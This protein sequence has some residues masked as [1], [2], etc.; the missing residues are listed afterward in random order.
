MSTVSTGSSVASST[1]QQQQQQQQQ[2]QQ[3]QYPPSASPPLPSPRTARILGGHH[4]SSA[5]TSPVSSSATPIP[6]LV[7]G[8][9]NAA[10]SLVGQLLSASG[11]TATGGATPYGMIVSAGASS[12]APEPLSSLP[13]GATTPGVGMGGIQATGEERPELRRRETSCSNVAVAGKAVELEPLELQIPEVAGYTD[14]SPVYSINHIHV[15]RAR[16]S[17]T[18]KAVV[19]KLCTV[20]HLDTLARLRLE[21]KMLS[22]VSTPSSKVSLQ[23]ATA[24]STPT[25]ERYGSGSLLGNCL[26]TTT[27]AGSPN[28][29]R[30]YAWD[31]LPEGGLTLIYSDEPAHM[32]VREAFLPD[33]RHGN[34]RPHIIGTAAP[35]TSG[36]SS[37]VLTA[38]PRTQSDLIKILTVFSSVV[39]VLD[40]A[41]KSGVTHNNINTFSILVTRASNSSGIHGKLGGW[42]LASR[43]ERQELGRGAGGA[44][45]RGENPA[46]LQYIAPECTGRMNRSVDYRADFYSLGVALYELVVGFLVRSPPCP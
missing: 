2:H 35:Q 27:L 26:P 10:T 43:L 38:K 16:S 9:V 3:Q 18:G 22:D 8:N 34:K 12:T 25:S 7:G 19:L 17:F 15:Y 33:G 14:L 32:T 29:V 20:N 42:H 45:L 44:M 40:S 36:G 24:S 37:R 23:S 30:P 11:N 6:L 5:S 28:V 4:F 41:H 31:Y 39:A 1:P 13:E 46:P 21:W